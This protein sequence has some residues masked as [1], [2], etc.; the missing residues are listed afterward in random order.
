MTVVFLW[1]LSFPCRQLVMCVGLAEAS[2]SSAL[3]PLG[4]ILAGRFPSL[5]SLGLNP[6]CA[7]PSSSLPVRRGQNGEVSN[8]RQTQSG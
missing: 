2:G 6:F 3:D 4:G 8:E 1:T 5:P 7:F